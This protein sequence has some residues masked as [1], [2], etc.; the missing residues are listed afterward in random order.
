MPQPLKTEPHGHLLGLGTGL[1][2]TGL[3]LWVSD[4]SRLRGLELMGSRA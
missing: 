2:L 1:G 4:L 3:G